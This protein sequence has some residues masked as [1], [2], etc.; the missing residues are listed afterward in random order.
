M[1]TSFSRSIWQTSCEHD[2]NPPEFSIY[3]EEEW[4]LNILF[5]PHNHDFSFWN[6]AHETD[7]VAFFSPRKH[8]K[9]QWDFWADGEDTGF[10]VLLDP[11]EHLEFAQWIDLLQADES[12]VAMFDTP[13][14]TL[15]RYGKLGPALTIENGLRGIIEIGADFS[16]GLRR[17]FKAKGSCCWRRPFLHG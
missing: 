10:A 12:W 5:R 17:Y 2:L 8:R 6:V 11:Y 16:S 1:L 9:D 14:S 7:L 13:T 15:P 4:G 3:A